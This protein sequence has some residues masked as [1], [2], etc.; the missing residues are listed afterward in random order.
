LFFNRKRNNQND[1]LLQVTE[2][3]RQSLQRELGSNWYLDVERAYPCRLV[4]EEGCE[5]VFHPA[6]VIIP[7]EQILK[8]EYHMSPQGHSQ[9]KGPTAAVFYGH[10]SNDIGITNFFLH[11]VNA[12]ASKTPYF[13]YK[14]MV[15]VSSDPFILETSVNRIRDH[16]KEFL[17]DSKS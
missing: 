14:A 7:R 4:A 12:D 13:G 16:F 9:K 15:T 1:A 3:I 10:H 8:P 11:T 2:Q 5:Q 17:D 6:V